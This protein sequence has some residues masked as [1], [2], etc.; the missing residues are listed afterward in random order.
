VKRWWVYYAYKQYMS[1]EWTPS[2][3]IV[4]ATDRDNALVTAARL[5]KDDITVLDVREA[6]T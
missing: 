3:S 2:V 4:D 1:N 6:L 5:L